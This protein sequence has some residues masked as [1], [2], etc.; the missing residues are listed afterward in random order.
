MNTKE[1]RGMKRLI[2]IDGIVM[3]RREETCKDGDSI[4]ESQNNK[5]RHRRPVALQLRPDD[6]RRRAVRFSRCLFDFIH[7]HSRAEVFSKYLR[8]STEGLPLEEKLN[9]TER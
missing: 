1:H 2:M 6:L 4:K 8:T 7:R 3:V 5:T 9:L